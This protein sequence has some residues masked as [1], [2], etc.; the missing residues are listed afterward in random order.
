MKIRNFTEAHEVLGKF[1]PPERRFRA[2]YNLDNMRLLMEEL[3]NP[4]DKLKVVHVAGTSGKTSPCYYVASLLQQTGSKIGLTV[5]PHVDE[6][7]ERLQINLVP[8]P[9]AEYCS[10]L[11]QILEII[12]PSNIKPTYFE[13]LV[14]FAYWEFARQN[15]DYVVVEVGLGGLLDGT[16]VVSREDKVCVI[17]DIGL[18][19]TNVLGKTIP[20]IA[21]QKSGIIQQHNAVFS[22]VQ[23]EEVMDAIKERCA[24]EHGQFFEIG[25]VTLLEAEALPLFQQHNWYLAKQ[26][27]DFIA[28]RDGL[29]KIS[30]K[31][32]HKSQE[33]YIPA[34]MEIVQKKDKTII[35]DGAHNPQKI[36]TL[37]KSLMAKYPGQKMAV[38]TGLLSDKEVNGVIKEIAPVTKQLYATA[39]K[40]EQDMPRAAIDPQEIVKVAK[41]VGVENAY[42][43]SRPE[44]AYKKALET[45]DMILVTGSFF[46]LNHIRPL[47]F[48]A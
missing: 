19:H 40:A 31:Q 20:E 42:A 47:I 25:P 1:V 15:V 7:N 17:T 37:V 13:L 22:Y 8:L 5:S 46:L 6:I 30:K 32:I 41:E 4:Q 21:S 35:L 10:E 29:K 26:V 18:D 44:D 38:V 12:G 34:R 3:G 48:K 11:S 16:N 23:S 43:I 24:H 2:K 33:A 14:A 39:F 36:Q 28:Q 45:S 27:V 9:E